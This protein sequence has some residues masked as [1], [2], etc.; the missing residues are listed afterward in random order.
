MACDWVVRRKFTLVYKENG[1]L[2]EIVIEDAYPIPVWCSG[3]YDNIP[4]EIAE[5]KRSTP[6][7][8]I[9]IYGEWVQT[10][11]DNI[12]YSIP[13]WCGFKSGTKTYYTTS[14]I[15]KLLEDCKVDLNNVF[16]ITATHVGEQYY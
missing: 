7:T 11:D 5:W 4:D 1:Q 6:D 14:C 10:N 2:K 12:V 3:C 13:E 9:Y 8:C 16:M 15:D